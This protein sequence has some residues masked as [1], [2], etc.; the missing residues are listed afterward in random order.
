[1][2]QTSAHKAID[3]L[4]LDFI[5]EVN[6]QFPSISKEKL[7]SIYRGNN[8]E[9]SDE[10]E[11]KVIAPEPTAKPVVKKTVEAK[12]AAKKD[13]GVSLDALKKI[14]KELGIPGV[15]KFKS[16]DKEELQR[17]IDEKKAN[18]NA[19]KKETKPGKVA[20]ETKEELTQKI[21]ARTQSIV[22]KKNQFGN[23]EHQ[24][25]R[26]V[27]DPNT[28]RAYGVQSDDGKIIPLTAHDI[29]KCE[30]LKFEYDLPSN[31]AQ[32]GGKKSITKEEINDDDYY[33]EEEEDIDD[34]EEEEEEE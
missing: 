5:T 16:T 24:G 34:I 22:I 26:I 17:L 19:G 10:E 4:F 23:Y 20:P 11:L 15:T 6:L 28:K 30:D 13:T 29:Q 32:A 2:Y 25:T 31:L 3:Q 8:V 12:P 18:P 1:M 21:Q 27:L 7:L 14:A 9:E 33:D